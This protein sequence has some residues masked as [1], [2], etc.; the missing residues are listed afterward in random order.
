METKEIVKAVDVVFMQFPLWVGLF[1]C[2]AVSM[3]SGSPKEWLMR[4]CALLVALIG[5]YVF[6]L[7]A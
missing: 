5:R 3:V 4:A 7:I 2:A 1:I 6:G